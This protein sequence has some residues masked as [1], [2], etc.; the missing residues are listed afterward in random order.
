MML[1]RMEAVMAM[2]RRRMVRAV[3]HQLVA[4]D[5]QGGFA[6]ENARNKHLLSLI[7][8]K[9]RRESKAHLSHQ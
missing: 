9:V 1:E 6:K 5:L 2:K 3:L 7:Q 8:L 4:L